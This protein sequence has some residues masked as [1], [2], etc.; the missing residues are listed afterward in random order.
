MRPQE[1]SDLRR[2]C[3]RRVHLI[4]LFPSVGAIDHREEL[5]SDG[6]CRTGSGRNSHRNLGSGLGIKQMA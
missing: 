2:R 4:D 1:F 5:A 6:T 3:T